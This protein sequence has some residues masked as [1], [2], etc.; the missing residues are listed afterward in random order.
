MEKGPLAGPFFWRHDPARS[1][2]AAKCAKCA[3]SS[4]RPMRR[5]PR[6]LLAIALTQICATLL[7]LEAA[8]R[9]FG[10]LSRDVSAL[11]YLPSLRTRYDDITSID[12]LMQETPLG[13]VPFTEWKGFILN[14]RSLRTKEYP[15]PRQAGAYRIVAIGDSFTVGAGE[16]DKTWPA[17]LENALADRMNRP[18]EVFALGVPG[19]GPQFELRLWELERDLLQPDL[20]IVAFFVGNDFTDDEELALQP[21]SEARL[22]R[23]SYTARLVRNLYRLRS[24]RSAGF[25][26][27]A[28]VPSRPESARHPGGGF[29]VPTDDIQRLTFSRERHLL[30]EGYRMQITMDDHRDDFLRLSTRVAQVLQR[31]QAEVLATGAQFLVMIIPDEFQV[32]DAVRRDVLERLDIESTAIHLDRPQTR[33]KELLGSAGVPYLDLLPAFRAAGRSERLYYPR[34][35]HWNDAGNALAARLLTD[36]VE[37][38]AGHAAGAGP[39]T[40]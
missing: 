20:V 9:I 22:L 2:S 38:F 31:F 30:I 1:H 36:R 23:A 26:G 8:L 37:G 40:R 21:S 39:A 15:A 34:N 4:L 7:L 14:S 13:F 18:I 32:D 12:A 29:A 3:E 16:H 28:S 11:L 19:V 10:P 24:E 35:T 33:L 27:R 6:R 17:L 25:E 5:D